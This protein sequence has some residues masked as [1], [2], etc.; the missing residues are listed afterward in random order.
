VISEHSVTIVVEIHFEVDIITIE[1]DNQ[2][3]IIQILVQKNI[4]EDVLLD[5][6]ASVNIIIEN[7][8]TKL[9][10]P[11]LRLTPYHLR[12]ANQNMTRPLGIIKNLKIHIQGIPY[13]A[14]FTVLQNGVV[15]FNYSM[16]LGKP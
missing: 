8:K 12:M 6:G 11:K 14:T 9:S 3:A 15:D 5:G 16:L 7:L 13:V 2:M 10:L 1:V 4:V